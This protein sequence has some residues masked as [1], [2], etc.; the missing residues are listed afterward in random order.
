MSNG[1]E[2][3]Q[4]VDAGA[5]ADQQDDQGGVASSEVPSGEELDQLDADMG[6]DR[7]PMGPLDEL[8]SLVAEGEGTPSDAPPTEIA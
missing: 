1:D 7:K 8:D 5:A 4:Q 3:P 6:V 2:Q